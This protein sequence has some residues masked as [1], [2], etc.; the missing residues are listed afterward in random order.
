MADKMLNELE[1]TESTDEDNSAEVR[2]LHTLNNV[3]RAE[4]GLLSLEAHPDHEKNEATTVVIDVL[5]N[6][7]HLCRMSDLD[8]DICIERASTHHDA[9]AEGIY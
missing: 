4:L 6:L 8:F 2:K 3:D 1:F 7:M 5:A 9:E